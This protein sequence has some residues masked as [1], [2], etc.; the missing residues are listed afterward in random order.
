MASGGT[1]L[2]G[3]GSALGLSV[4]T[5]LGLFLVRKGSARILV[6][7]SSKSS[8]QILCTAFLAVVGTNPPSSMVS[9]N[10]IRKT[11]QEGD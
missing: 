4:D 9:L 8:Q 7:T 3:T 6:T 1:V 11:T 2:F 10:V 5:D